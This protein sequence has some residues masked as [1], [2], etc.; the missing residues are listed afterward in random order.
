MVAALQTAGL[1][2][3]AVTGDTTQPLVS[4]T[5]SGSPIVVGQQFVRGTAIDLTFAPTPTTTTIR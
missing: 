4:A 5:A 2:V 1:A 3:G